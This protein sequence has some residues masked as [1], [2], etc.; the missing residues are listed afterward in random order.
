VYQHND[1][2]KEGGR[3]MDNMIYILFISISIPLLLMALLMEKKARL[4]IS[5]MIIGIFVSVFAS[6]V[7]G[8][9]SN[10]LSMDTY[11]MTVIVTPVSEE[12][13]KALPVLYYA[14]VI[15]DK[16]ERLFTASMAIGIGFALL[17][18]AY[19][20]LNSDNFT[21]IIAIIR[22]FG[23]GLMHGMCTLLVGV[24]ISFVKKKRKLFAVGTFGL[25]S[26]A[27]VYH[28]IYNIL[29]QSEFSTVG[30]ILPIATY[31]P[32]LIRRLRVKNRKI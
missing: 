17:E 1:C 30:A 31:I 2:R 25:L 24:G 8:L 6:E 13:L 19:F 22:A 4:P 26:T 11:S 27:I 21:I 28:G 20:L 29:I 15:S 10:L 32:F 9:L 3:K 16:R 5:F 14:I 7:N 12:L 18:N 23:A